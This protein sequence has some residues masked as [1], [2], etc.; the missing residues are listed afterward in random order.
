MRRSFRVR[1]AISDPV[2][3]DTGL[4]E[5]DSMSCVCMVLLNFV[6]HAYMSKFAP[7]IRELSYVDNLQLVSQS[8]GS[9]IQGQLVAETWADM[10]QLQIDSAKS[11]YWGTTASLRHLLSAQ[12]FAAVESARSWGANA[13]WG[14][15]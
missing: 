11:T 13:I 12:G 3:S 7:G 4:P 8:V 14:S 5:G 9:L 1:E 2:G 10:L 6:F 15:S